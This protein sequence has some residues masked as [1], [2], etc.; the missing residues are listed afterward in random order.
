ELLDLELAEVVPP[1]TLVNTLQ[2][3]LP[4]GI[5][6]LTAEEVPLGQKSLA[7]LLEGARWIMGFCPESGVPL[8]RQ[9][10]QAAC[11]A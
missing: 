9:S 3:Q 2:P 10:W 4:T 5:Q 6:L 7:Q 8:P 1:A 11:E